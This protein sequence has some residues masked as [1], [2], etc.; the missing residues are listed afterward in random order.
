VTADDGKFL[1]V[2]LKRSF[3]ILKASGF[4]GYCS[5]EY[6]THGDPYGPTARLIEETIEY[7]S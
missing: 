5:M 2:D 7:L 4:R 6:D 1:G 3:E